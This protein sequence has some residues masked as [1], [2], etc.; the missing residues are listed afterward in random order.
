MADYNIYFQTVSA[1]SSAI[2]AIASACVA[3]K[4]FSIQINSLLKKEIVKQI[5]NVLQLL[6]RLK[7]YTGQTALGASDAEFDGLKPLIL[8]AKDS[9]MILESMSSYPESADLRKVRDIVHSLDEAKIF[10]PGDNVPNGTLEKQK[11]DVA[12]RAI[13][14]VYSMEI[15]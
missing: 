6:Y 2:A 14:N 15:K 12:I 7:S 10:A 3:K 4:T 13:Q 5:M 1:V 8:K 9:V 11:L